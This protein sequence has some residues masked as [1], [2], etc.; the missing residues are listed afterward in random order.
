VSRVAPLLRGALGALASTWRVDTQDAHHLDDLRRAGVP[1]VVVLW[2]HAVLPLFWWHRHQG[3]TLV[4]S[5]NRDGRLLADAAHGWGYE[6]IEGSSSRGGALALRQVM[7]TLQRGGEV[8]I[9]PDGPRGP[10]R[11]AKAGAASAAQAV[12]AAVVPVG[13]GWSRAWRFGS[14]DA[15]A[16]PPPFAR[17]CVVYGAPF[18]VEPGEAGL[19]PGVVRVQQ[20]LDHASQLAACA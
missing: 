18:R 16:V 14:W 20:A 7:R 10:G 6:V 19:A 9:T 1:R 17:L 12:G 3:T 4:V 5:R 15:I 8:A 13:L 11:V 2:H